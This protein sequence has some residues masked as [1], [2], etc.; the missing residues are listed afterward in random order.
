MKPPFFS[1]IIPTK[2]RPELLRKAI[3]SVLLQDFDDYEL[4]VSDN[5]NDQKTFDVVNEFKNDEHLNYVRTDREMNMPDHWEFAARKAKG[6]YVMILTDRSFLRQGS[7][8]DI[9][10]S[11]SG[12]EV[13]ACFWKHGYYDE[14]DKILF[15][16]REEEGVKFLDS[17]Q[18][19]KGF[20]QT[21]SEGFL[22]KPCSGCYK[23][24]FAQRIINDVG[25]LYL[26]VNPDYT[27]ALLFLAY[28]D[29]VAYIPRTLLFFQGAT[30]SNL[31]S[32]RF[33]P[34]LYIQSL[35]IK[36]PYKFVPIK[37]SIGS[38][39]IFNDFLMVQD[40]VG[41]NLK[42]VKID[43][44]FYFARCYIELKG[45]MTRPEADKK[46]QVEFFKEWKRAL[47]GFNPKLRL[48]SWEKI[49]FSYKNIFKSYLELIPLAGFLIRAKRF[50]LG[51][52]ANKYPDALS[53]GGFNLDK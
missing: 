38:S 40:L 14:K 25:N 20:S 7:L 3:S 17:K 50:F 16:D 37:A 48:R 23:R 35:K 27:P 44:A 24:D 52:P 53:A 2:N 15:G 6:S 51:K 9:Y 19:I 42:G 36:D 43:W 1:V 5:F 21:L 49:C 31:P 10:N 47:S 22:P 41:R 11:I 39:L 45:N 32:T 13:N 33:N 46:A 26:P 12:K 34:K 29:S 28:S 30:V 8:K 4:V 18:L